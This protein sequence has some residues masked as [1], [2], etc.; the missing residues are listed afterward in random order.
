MIEVG[1][2]VVSD[3]V[4]ANSSTCQVTD[5]QFSDISNY[6]PDTWF[7]DFGDGN[8]SILQNPIHFYQDSGT[9]NVNLTVSKN[10]ENVFKTFKK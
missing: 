7:W 2:N 5:I 3:F 1:I 4:V 9:Y 6:N 10:G 8:T